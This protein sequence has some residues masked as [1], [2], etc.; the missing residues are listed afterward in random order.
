MRVV[1]RG[2]DE[3]DALNPRKF[4]AA[5]KAA[6]RAE[7][8]VDEDAFVIICPARV[9]D[10]KGQHVLVEAMGLLSATVKPY[11][12]CVGSAQG[13]DAYVDELRALAAAGNIAERLVLAGHESDMPSAYAA[14]NMAVLPTIEA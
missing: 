3:P 13:R 11:L 8:G 9:T 10:L 2:C 4:L 1:P 14:A 12:V 5:D 7:W 6:K